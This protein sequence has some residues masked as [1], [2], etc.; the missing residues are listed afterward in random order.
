M[1]P[2]E[3]DVHLV[4]DYAGIADTLYD[5]VGSRHLRREVTGHGNGERSDL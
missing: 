1:L 5:I 2:P 3:S 4:E